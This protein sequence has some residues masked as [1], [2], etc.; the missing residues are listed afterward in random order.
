MAKSGQTDNDS[1][2][3]SSDSDE[4]SKRSKSRNAAVADQQELSGSRDA[5]TSGSVGASTRAGSSSHRIGTTSRNGTAVQTRS[6]ATAELQEA[7]PEAQQEEIGAGASQPADVQGS[8]G[9]PNVSVGQQL[10]SIEQ[11]QQRKQPGN[12]EQPRIGGQDSG[13]SQVQDHG[14]RPPRN[15]VSPMLEVQLVERRGREASVGSEVHSN[16]HG[17]SSGGGQLRQAAAGSMVRQHRSH[18]NVDKQ[19]SSAGPQLESVL[20]DAAAKLTSSNLPSKGTSSIAE[21]YTGN[22]GIQPA[23]SE[24]TVM[25]PFSQTP[26]GPVADLRGCSDEGL[27]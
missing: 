2:A 8:A 17:Q 6:D 27:R 20:A 13:D 7:G 21:Y 16:N 12:P 26:S 18:S 14:K 11:Q 1:E 24:A 4:G 22:S 23:P 9:L 25:A 3:S 5:A 15:S 10:T 19:H